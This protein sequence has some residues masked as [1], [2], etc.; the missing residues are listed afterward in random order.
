MFKL[1]VKIKNIYNPQKSWVQDQYR[2]N[3]LTIKIGKIYN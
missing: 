3:S 1:T 2:A